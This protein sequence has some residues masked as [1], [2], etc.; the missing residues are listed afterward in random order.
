MNGR[1][2]GT[3]GGP[4]G[5][6]PDHDLVEARLAARLAL[7]LSE[8]ADRLPADVAERLRFVITAHGDRPVGGLV[9]IDFA[10]AV[11]VPWAST[12]RSE[13]QRCPNNQI[14]WEALRWSIGR[15]D[16]SPA[17]PGCACASSLPS[18]SVIRG[19]ACARRRPHMCVCAH[20]HECACVR[21][22]GRRRHCRTPSCLPL[23]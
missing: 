21:A 10:G 9:A 17:C 22:R 15:S 19:A 6:A 13:R 8:S 23:V 7:A 16:T 20:A 11:T 4:P 5:A 18:E 3:M 1:D 14:Y 12:L 2:E